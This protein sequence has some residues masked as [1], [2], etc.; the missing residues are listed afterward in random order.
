MGNLLKTAVIQSPATDRA[1]GDALLA[2]RALVEL[3]RG[4]SVA[5]TDKRDSSI[6]VAIEAVT[7]DE[8]ASFAADD[9][10]LR[11]IVAADRVKALGLVPTADIMRLAVPASVPP[12]ALAHLI[13]LEVGGVD[14][15]QGPDRAIAALVAAANN[16]HGSDRRIDVASLELSPANACEAI[17]LE[18]VKQTQLLPALF[19]LGPIESRPDS[20]RLTLSVADATAYPVARARAIRRVSSARVPLADHEAC[21][22]IVYRERFGDAEHVAIIVGEPDFASP[23]P[24]R[25][26]SSCLTGDLFG[27]LRCDCGEQL[28]SAVRRISDAGG[29]VLLYLAHEGRGIG[30]ANKLRAYQLQESGLDTL[31]ADRHLGFRSDERDYTAA[32]AMLDDLAI[33]R[34]VLLTNNPG[35]I[36]ALASGGIEVVDRMPLLVNENPH[37]AR[38]MQAKRENAGHYGAVIS[39]QAVDD[40]SVGTSAA[41]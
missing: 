32:C 22:F 15:S 39:A 16:G 12:A 11:V 19:A 26:H 6:L 37:N 2:D 25:M 35:K 24:V 38:Y 4:R 23:V 41:D 17:G 10:L 1:D 34:I 27:S 18:L 5:I 3:R 33:S 31:Q 9:G 21:R 36:A 30:L 7:D 29:G 40:A 20:R 14:F 28:R 8:Y 13:G